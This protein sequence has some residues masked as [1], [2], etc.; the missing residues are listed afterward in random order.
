[1][2]PISAQR[3]SDQFGAATLDAV[4]ESTEGPALDEL[5][6]KVRQMMVVFET[7]LMLMRQDYPEAARIYLA[8]DRVG[9]ADFVLWGQYNI[10]GMLPALQEKLWRHPDVPELN[11]WVESMY[12]TGLVDRAQML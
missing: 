7:H 1:M 3:K 4:M 2:D 9:Y 6:A 12:A 11:K 8:G 10:T 5:C